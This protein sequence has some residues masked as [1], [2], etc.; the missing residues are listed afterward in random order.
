MRENEVLIHVTRGPLV[1]SV[2]HGSIAVVRSD[3]EMIA[4]KGNPRLVTYARSSMKP[5]QSIPIV[6]T[7]AADAFEMTAAELSLTTASHN[8]EAY[9]TK[10]AEHVLKK[11]ALGI[12]DLQ[13]G[14]HPPRY[15]TAYE[16]FIRE[17]APLTPI[18]N[19][20]SGKHS[21][22]LATAQHMGETTADYYQIEHPVQQRILEVIEDLCAIEREEIQ[23]GV[24]GCGVPVHGL[25]LQ[26]LALGFSQLADPSRLK[27]T[28]QQ[29]IQRITSAMMEAPEM[30]AGSERFC[31]DLMRAY[32]GKLFGKVGAEGVYC[33]GIPELG[34]GIALK[35]ADGNARATAPVALEVLRQ[36]DYLPSGVEEQ[37]AAYIQPILKNARSE[38]IGNLTPIFTLER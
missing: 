36:L 22:M 31:T 20:C 32:D 7:G 6:E 26:Q 37:L 2:H 18:Y 1:E 30:V 24:D 28:R 14:V 11:A 35:I 5:L 29:A 13:C 12:D 34:I 3:G 25:P 16:T 38:E 17:Q 15:P 21:G 27:E 8:G 23:I 10:T 9:H 33:I 19:N 4:W